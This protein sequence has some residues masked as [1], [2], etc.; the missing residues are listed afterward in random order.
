MTKSKRTLRYYMGDA[1]NGSNRAWVLILAD[2]EEEAYKRY[3]EC[4]K[5][6]EQLNKAADPQIA[7]C[8]N[9]D[10]ILDRFNNDARMR[11]LKTYRST[12]I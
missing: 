3:T 9:V 10:E 4:I 8:W 7:E 2:S 5:R 6:H 12:I 11:E 1:L